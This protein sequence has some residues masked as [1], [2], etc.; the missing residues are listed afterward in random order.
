MPV[1]IVIVMGVSG[2]GKSTVGRLLAERT[3]WPFIDGDDYHSPASIEKMRAGLALTDEDRAPWLATLAGLLRDAREEQRPVI[4]GCSA[5]RRA[6]RDTL[7]GGRRDDVVLVHLV[8][9][10]PVVR[11]RMEAR[12][13]FMPPGNLASQLAALELPDEDE[14]PLTLDVR[15][16]PPALV[17]RIIEELRYRGALAQA[18]R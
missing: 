4:L 16:S 14:R 1:V 6:Y 9:G 7:T 18:P 11:S 13:H 2:S 5:L 17:D 12:D 10:A 15:E 8:G 3:G